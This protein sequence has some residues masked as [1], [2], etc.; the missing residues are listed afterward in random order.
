MDVRSRWASFVPLPGPPR[1]AGLEAASDDLFVDAVRAVYAQ[2]HARLGARALA[3]GDDAAGLAS[4][5]RAEALDPGD[6]HVALLLFDVYRDFGIRR[7]RWRAIL[8][9]A[10]AEYDRT[11]DPHD[12]RFDW[13]QRRDLE[14]R[15][16]SLDAAATDPPEAR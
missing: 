14:Q 6:P 1:D 9:R 11:Y 13:L 16:S 12:A 4:L 7:E 3:R 15:L 5:D 2:Y 8:E 10:L